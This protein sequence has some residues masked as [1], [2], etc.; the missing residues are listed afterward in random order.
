MEPLKPNPDLID[1]NKLNLEG[2]LS[3]NKIE[4]GLE[5]EKEVFKVEKEGTAEISVAEKDGN[6]AKIISKIKTDDTVASLDDVVSDDA[7]IVSQKTDAETQINH[8]VDIASIKGVVHAV[9][10]AK[11]L[12][13]NYVLDT[14][15]D[16]LLSDE[17]HD[18]LVKKGIIKEI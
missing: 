7:K 6:Y 8:L 4:D 15:H 11:H 17:F 9:K 2:K 3:E 13:D 5:K 16:R 14:F 12:Q 10:V 1:E 18:A